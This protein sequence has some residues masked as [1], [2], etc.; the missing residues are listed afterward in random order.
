MITILIIIGTQY[1][2]FTQGLNKFGLDLTL[3][4]AKELISLVKIY[5]Q[6]R[7]DAPGKSTRIHGGEANNIDDQLS[8]AIVAGCQTTFDKYEY[9]RP[10]NESDGLRWDLKNIQLTKGIPYKS[11][12]ISP[13]T[14]LGGAGAIKGTACMPCEFLNY[15]FEEYSDVD[16]RDEFSYY[17]LTKEKCTV[18][19]CELMEYP[20]CTRVKPPGLHLD[21]TMQELA[22]EAEEAT[23]EIEADVDELEAGLVADLQ[24]AI[25][26][27]DDFVACSCA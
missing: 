25:N 22:I 10:P 20:S 8:K 19:G 9:Q 1:E 6:E 2:K 26:L 23:L 7:A 4:Q 3:S 16:C 15:K 24:L 13:T 17:T 11:V 18:D 5:T 21:G 27:A 14:W 12:S